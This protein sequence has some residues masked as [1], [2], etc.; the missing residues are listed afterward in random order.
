MV[1][2]RRGMEF[3]SLRNGIQRCEP[4]LFGTRQGPL[5]HAFEYKNEILSL[6]DTKLLAFKVFSA[7]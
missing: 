2:G 1:V 4:H 6:H 3:G 7:R 5:V